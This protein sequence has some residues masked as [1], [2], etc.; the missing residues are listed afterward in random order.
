MIH[1]PPWP[2]QRPVAWVAVSGFPAAWDRP[3]RCVGGLQGRPW[4]DV[5]P[6]VHLASSLASSEVTGVGHVLWLGI[7]NPQG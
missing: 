2:F 6:H 7:L 4:R 3:E 1:R 5:R